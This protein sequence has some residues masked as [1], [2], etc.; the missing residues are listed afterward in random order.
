MN[1]ST[2]S[3]YL[4]VALTVMILNVGP[5]ASA[6]DLPACPEIP[7]GCV[8]ELDSLKKELATIWPQDQPLETEA[9][10][11]KML[12]ALEKWRS[13]IDDSVPP[14]W[15]EKIKIFS[16]QCGNYDKKMR[17]LQAQSQISQQELAEWDRYYA[18]EARP[19]WLNSMDTTQ[20]YHHLMRHYRDAA[21]FWNQVI[22]ETEL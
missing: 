21:T 9:N 6:A 19:L 4:S 22:K 12:Q 1:Q 3:L 10:A 15:R 16:I 7:A 20:T 5:A 11:R 14:G 8:A 18:E 2:L 13:R 17:L